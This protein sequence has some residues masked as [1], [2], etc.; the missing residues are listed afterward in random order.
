MLTIRIKAEYLNR[1]IRPNF[2]LIDGIYTMRATI[3]GTEWVSIIDYSGLG[4][5]APNPTSEMRFAMEAWLLDTAVRD[6][7]A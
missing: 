7:C 3:N 1:V 2:R 5:T 6:A 4:V